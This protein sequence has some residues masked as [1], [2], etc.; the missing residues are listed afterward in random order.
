MF[1]EV[2]YIIHQTH[3]KDT[4]SSLPYDSLYLLLQK[5]PNKANTF[6][7]TTLLQIT[8]HKESQV[9]KYNLS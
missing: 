6:N 7:P 9:I 4:S 1:S 8:K 3:T 2:Y 5:D